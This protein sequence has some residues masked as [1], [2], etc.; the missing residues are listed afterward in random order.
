MPGFKK[1]MKFTMLYPPFNTNAIIP[2]D[3][4]KVAIKI[5]LKRTSHSLYIQSVMLKLIVTSKG[6]ECIFYLLHT[7]KL[8]SKVLL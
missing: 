3:H 8:I 2:F 7:Q 4:N 5:L 6:V 1:I